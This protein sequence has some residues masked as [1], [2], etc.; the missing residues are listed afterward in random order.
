[1]QHYSTNKTGG[2]AAPLPLNPSYTHWI[3]FEI[4]NSGSN[5]CLEKPCFAWVLFKVNLKT[6]G[7]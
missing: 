4:N 1:M 6:A 2:L 5:K 7:Q 3:Q